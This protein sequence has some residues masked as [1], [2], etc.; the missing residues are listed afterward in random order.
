MNKVLVLSSIHP[1]TIAELSKHLYS[2]YGSKN[3][4]F[5]IQSMALLYEETFNAKYIPANYSFANALKKDA[6]IL[7]DKTQNLI[8]FGNL[9]IATKINFDYVI[10]YSN[11]LEEDLE[12]KYLAQMSKLI[13]LADTTINIEWFKTNSNTVRLVVP[14][15]HHLDTFLTTLGIEQNDNNEQKEEDN[16]NNQ[17]QS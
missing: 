4:V 9:D 15:L 8:V 5:S 6:T 7:K 17:L 10:I 11:G 1:I 14:T 16:D 3:S 12:D 13:N 2:K